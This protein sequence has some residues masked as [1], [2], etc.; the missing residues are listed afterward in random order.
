[1]N[2]YRPISVLPILSKVFERII[3]NRLYDY[4][5]NANLLNSR[6][7]GFRKRHSTGTCLIEFLDVIYDNIHE[8][9]LSGV[10]FLDLKKAFDTVDHGVV[11]STL[12]KLN[13]SPAVL[14]WFESYL[15]P[16]LQITRVNGK[17]SNSLN[18]VCGVPQGS[19]LG[20]LL[21]VLYI[22]RLPS[23]INSDCFLYADDTAIVCTG[24][25]VEDIIAR[26]TDELSAAAAWL[27]DHK[28][29]LNLKK[30]KAM[31]FGTAMK[32]KQVEE[33]QL[34]FNSTN[35]DIVESY[36]YLGIMLDGPLRFDKHVTYLQSRLFPKM[37]T[38]SRIRCYIGQKTAL[39]L[40]STLINPLF[41]FNDY[42]YDALSAKDN[43]KLQVIQN[44]CLRTCLKADRL[45]PR[46]ELYA[47]SGVKPL[48]IQRRENTSGI[49]YLGLNKL[50]TPFV[51]TMF[52][53]TENWTMCTE[54]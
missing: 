15:T 52:S 37:K 53:K 18:I 7:S 36:K 28:L 12:S 16:R 33:K 39:Y 29:T 41:T 25:T 1:M 6:Q 3:H 19:I 35:I 11:I 38:L 8:G 4:V 27:S 34:I 26:M 43:S 51:N 9:R 42:I 30:T 22:N 49:V 24:N 5:S 17:D 47:T 48:A 13:M 45:T 2:N 14:K 32:L 10:L 40:Y 50:S 44:T 54:I 21:F 31:F 46:N 23:V 20:P